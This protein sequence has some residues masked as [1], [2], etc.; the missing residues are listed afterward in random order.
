MKSGFLLN[1][2][3]PLQCLHSDGAIYQHR[4]VSL[5]DVYPGHGVV[6]SLDQTPEVVGDLLNLQS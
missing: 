4:T 5:W 1:E 6:E 3:A 2:G